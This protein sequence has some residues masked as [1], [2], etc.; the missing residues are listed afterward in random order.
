[1]IDMPEL[2]SF[3]KQDAHFH[4]NAFN[5]AYLRIAKEYSVRYLT[6]NTDTAI[7]PPLDKQEAVALELI[8]TY[9]QLFAYICSFPMKGWEEKGWLETVISSIV[10][11]VAQGAVGVKIWKNIGMELRKADGSFLMA[12]DAV[13]DPIYRYLSDHAIPVLAHLG[14]PRNC[15]LPLEAMTTDRNRNYYQAHPEFHAYLHPEIPGYA[16]QLEARDNV[17]A[18]YPGLIFVGAHLGSMEWSIDELAKRLDRYPNFS[19]DLSSRIGHLQLQS[20]QRYEAV[21]AFMIQYADRILYG[22]DA[23][24]NPAKLEAALVNDWTF[25]A[26]EDYGPSPEVAGTFRGLGLPEEVLYKIYYANAHRI[27]ARLRI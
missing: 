6:I 13:F 1:M 17:L 18:R 9:P 16:A 21:Q 5:P 23:Y 25:L 8:R 12:D 24:D 4:A 19:V 14:E 3:P 15:W 11:S 22:T 2:Q 7:F 20:V 10:R 27:Y 26:T